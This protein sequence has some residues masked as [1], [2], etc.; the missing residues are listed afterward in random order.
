L[1]SLFHIT[2]DLRRQATTPEIAN[3]DR[4]HQQGRE[5]IWSLMFTE[6]TMWIIDV[7]YMVD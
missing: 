2:P 5:W 1:F 4:G 7:I 6:W 3:V